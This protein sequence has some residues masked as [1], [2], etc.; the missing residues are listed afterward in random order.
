MTNAEKKRKSTENLQKLNEKVQKMS[1]LERKEYYAKIA[2]TR[3]AN[4]E[5]AQILSNSLKKIV[6]GTYIDEKDGSKL[7][8]A[9]KMNI[10]ITL[11][12]MEGDIGAYSII[13]DTIGEKPTDKVES[14]NKV[15][16]V[17]SDDLKRLS[18]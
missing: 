7:T 9:D 4:K 5:K 18:Q 6:N 12:A 15:E 13:R 1:V 8:I 16:F 10:A 11:K 14:D 3:R 17:L 2:A